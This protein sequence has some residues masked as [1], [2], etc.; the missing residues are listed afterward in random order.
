L[1]GANRSP[2][3]GISNLAEATISVQRGG[4]FATGV[5]D[6]RRRLRGNR[7]PC[8]DMVQGRARGRRPADRSGNSKRLHR[9]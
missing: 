5:N 3:H 1:I 4:G 9:V 8:S 2:A 7:M 6:R